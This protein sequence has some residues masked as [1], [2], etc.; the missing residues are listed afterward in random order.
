MEVVQVRLSQGHGLGSGR[1]RNINKLYMGALINIL[2]VA[3][4]IGIVGICYQLTGEMAK[5]R[6]LGMSQLLE[7]MM[8]NVQR[9]IP[10]VARLAAVHAAFDILYLPS[11]VIMA[12]IVAGLNYSQTNPGVVIGYFILAG[13]ALSSWSLAF[14]SLF[15]KAQLSGITVTIVS[16]ILAIIIQVIPPVGTGAAVVLSLLFPPMNFTLFIIYMA[17]WQKQ[18]LP[19]D[20][21]SAAPGAPWRVAGWVF[22]LFCGLQIACRNERFALIL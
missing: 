12:A 15:R 19:A 1:A 4:F 10:Q 6:E 13:L 18:Y 5:E 14:A 9:W 22:F 8:P 17:Y 21:S 2:A 16:I 7:A 11:W 3:Y 20:L